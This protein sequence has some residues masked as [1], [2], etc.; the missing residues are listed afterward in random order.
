LDGEV[1][2]INTAISSR[3]GGNDG[4]GF[5]VPVNLAK[6]VAEQL[7]NN[8]TVQRAYLGVGIQ[9]VTQQLADQFNVKPREGVVVTDVFPDTPAAKAGLKSG[10]VI[11]EFAGVKVSSAQELQ[12]LV[13]R[14]E[15]GKPHAISIIRGGKQR[16]LAFTPEAQPEDY[17]L[18][19]RGGVVPRE[20]GATRLDQLGLEISALDPAIAERLGVEGV[21]G[22]VITNVRPDSPAAKAG[23]RSGQ[24]ITQ[25][26]SVQVSGLDEAAQ[27]LKE[28]DGENGILLL[29]RSEQGSRFVVLKG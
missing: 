2:G 15:L 22:V 5:T 23:L 20:P 9:P 10:D 13:E 28:A 25:I 27:A 16:E 3:S 26:N 7:V 6:W 4:I 17:G 29:I 24:V 19:R 21:K 8:G 1:I 18:A 12:T 11:V 14:A